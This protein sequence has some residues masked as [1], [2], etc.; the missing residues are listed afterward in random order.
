[1]TSSKICK[2][3]YMVNTYHWWKFQV[4]S[5]CSSG[6]LELLES[7]FYRLPIMCILQIRTRIFCKNHKFSLKLTFWQNSTQIDQ[8]NLILGLVCK[9]HTKQVAESK[10]VEFLLFYG[11]VLLYQISSQKD[12]FVVIFRVRNFRSA[13]FKWVKINHPHLM[14]C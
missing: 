12:C 11:D 6:D 14:Y 3:S 5:T 2:W 8:V 13:G 4:K 9:I 7:V 1:M 10:Q